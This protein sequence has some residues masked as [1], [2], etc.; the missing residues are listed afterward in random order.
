[1]K[2]FRKMNKLGKFKFYSVSSSFL[3]VQSDDTHSGGD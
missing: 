1:M 2:M 3:V